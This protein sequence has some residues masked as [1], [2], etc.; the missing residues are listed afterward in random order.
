MWRSIAQL[1]FFT[2]LLPVALRANVTVTP[3]AGLDAGGLA[4][5]SLAPSLM[6]VIPLSARSGREND[7]LDAVT[8]R[9]VYRWSPA[10][11]PVK[12]FVESGMDVPGYRPIDRIL[13]LGAFN[14]WERASNNKLAWT[15][16]SKPEDA[17]IVCSWTNQPSVRGGALE[18]GNTVVCTWLN[19]LTGRGAIVSAHIKILTELGY[20]SFSDSEMKR[21]CLHEVGHALGL[22]GHSREYNDVMYPAATGKQLPFLTTRDIDT[23][24]ALY[25]SYDV[26]GPAIASEPT[27][28]PPY[29]S[30][31]DEG[32]RTTLSKMSRDVQDFMYLQG[33]E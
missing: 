28:A 17:D 13:L 27:Q 7:Y 26:L 1:I 30:W 23:I 5:P 29:W 4:A 32:L 15:L 33:T 22:Q 20:N 25:S 12:V 14:D 16:V 24:R 18:A 6:H 11:L 21:I 10:R 31:V 19:R 8:E 3:A 9:G 2:M